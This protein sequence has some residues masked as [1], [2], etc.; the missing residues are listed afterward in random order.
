[1]NAE[2]LPATPSSG[3]LHKEHDDMG[4]Q[5]KSEKRLGYPHLRLAAIDAVSLPG[6]PL[7]LARKESSALSKKPFFQQLLLDFAVGCELFYP[8][9]LYEHSATRATKALNR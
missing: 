6:L 3:G 7:S 8:I 9:Q 2:I 4:H 5:K 1:M